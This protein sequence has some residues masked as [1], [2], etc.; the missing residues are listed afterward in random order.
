MLD[1]ARN[2]AVLWT[3][4]F[5]AELPCES[6]LHQVGRVPCSGPGVYFVITACGK[7]HTACKNAGEHI[8]R[9][10]EEAKRVCI[11]R[12]PYQECVSIRPI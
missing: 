1:T 4:D 8:K 10:I 5:N 6:Q 3:L 12:A 7:R 9:C 2:Q 11:C